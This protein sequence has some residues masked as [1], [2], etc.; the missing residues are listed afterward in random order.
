ML[1]TDRCSAVAILF[2]FLMMYSGNVML[3]R[4]YFSFILLSCK[5]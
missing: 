5:L 4:L 2:S 1:D 3:I